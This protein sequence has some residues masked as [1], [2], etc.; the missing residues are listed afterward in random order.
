M[1][2]IKVLFIEQIVNGTANLR[3]LLQEEPDIVIVD[4]VVAPKGV[5][6]RLGRSLPM[7]SSWM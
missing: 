6:N 2:Q 1:T 4:T 7:S 3:S 5:G